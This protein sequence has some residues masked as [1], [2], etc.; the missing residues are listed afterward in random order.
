LATERK[1]GL[2]PART[3][4]GPAD[5]EETV[6]IG[7]FSLV[8]HTHLPWL[9]HHGAWPV[10]EEWL[11]QVWASSYDPLAALLERFADEGRT[12]VLTLGIT[13]VLAAQLDDPYSLR[14]HHTWLGFWQARATG[15]AAHRPGPLPAAEYRA[16]TAALERFEQRWSRGGS[17]VWRPL[18]DAGT[19]DLLSGPATH[20]F[21]P[22]LREEV[23][24]FGLRTGLAD[25]AL[26]VG[27]RRA[28]IWAPEC[29]YRPGMERAYADAGVTHLMLD[30]PAFAEAGAPVGLGA[31]LAGTDVVAFARDL[32]TSYRVW[33]PTRG[34]P[35]NPWYRDFYTYDHDWGFRH[36]RVTDAAAP[37]KAPYEPARAAAQVARDAQDFVA[38]V[39]ERLLGLRAELGRP[40]HVV[41]AF[42]TELFG[43]W[44]YEGPDWLAQV[45]RL[46]PQ[47]GVRV[48]TLDRARQDGFVGAPVAPAEASWGAGKKY[49]TW[50][51]PQVADMVADNRHLQDVVLKTLA[52]LP[53]Q[54]GRDPVADQLVRS[55]L[56]A[57]ASD[58]AFMVTK[59]SAAGYARRRHH[60]HHSDTHRLAGL[61]ADYGPASVPA[62]RE[63]AEQQRINGPFGHLD[64]RGLRGSDG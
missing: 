10:G 4:A 30:G 24:S 34:Y 46:L 27:S 12:D 21:G 49:Q 28:G 37:D 38:A 63:A 19:V 2:S 47:A 7:A 5:R 20:P 60:C 42:D 29:A 35:R 64:A 54:A 22:F 45:L 40:A 11:H 57:L 62:F 25:T 32:Q 41:A 61:V 8:L 3:A 36:S 16:A 50:G 56:L 43:H 1:L 33:S 17:A 44:W 55:M 15:Q 9:A 59:D 18:V 13:P 53:P 14:N 6:T 39:R 31:A 52:N 48:T 58:W 23:L 51:G 26:R